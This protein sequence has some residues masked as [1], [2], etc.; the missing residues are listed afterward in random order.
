MAKSALL[1]TAL[2]LTSAATFAAD[3][4]GNFVES[5]PIISVKKA[6]ASLLDTSR[7]DKKFIERIAKAEATEFMDQHVVMIYTD[8]MVGEE[9][10]D[11]HPEPLAIG[12][13]SSPMPKAEVNALIGKPVCN[14]PF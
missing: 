13:F 6:V 14:E 11:D 5:L 3:N 2:L 12:A 10:Y 9:G 7:C 1:A 8:S 4:A